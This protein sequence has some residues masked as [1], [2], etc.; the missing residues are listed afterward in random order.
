MGPALGIVLMQSLGFTSLFLASA[1]IGLM[2]F[3]F[4]LPVR[5]PARHPRPAS[6]ARPPLI[7]RP[8]LFPA[9]VLYF[10][11]LTYGAVVTFLPLFAVTRGLSNPG[12]FF[13]VQALVILALR[14]YI[15]K[16]TDRFGRGAVAI[17]G[18]ILA[19]VSTALLSQ[20]SSLPVFLGI[21][22]L[23]AI[24]F[25]SIQTSLTALVIDRVKPELR[26]AAMGTYIS[27][28]DAGIGSGAFLWGAVAGW[29]GYSNMYLIASVMPLIGVGLFILISRRQEKSNHLAKR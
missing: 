11:V 12:L 20:A 27:A 5:A 29:W 8:A 17:P 19:A 4:S 3:A 18:L 2:A 9:I 10:F 21:G 22:A 16:L 1:T 13:T 24:A 26:G 6:G 15:G 7:V 14:G 23:F 25:A 28:M